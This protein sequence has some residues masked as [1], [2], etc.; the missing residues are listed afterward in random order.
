MRQFCDTLDHKVLSHR[1]DTGSVNSYALNQ[2]V[3]N[4]TGVT[5]MAMRDG[6][7]VGFAEYRDSPQKNSPLRTCQVALL[8]HQDHHKQG[9]G[10]TL[11]NEVMRIAKENGFQ[12]IEW[13][14]LLRNKAMIEMIKKMDLSL[15]RCPDDSG[16]LMAVLAEKPAVPAD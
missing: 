13:A 14:M 11:N 8:V 15:Q 5:L 6:K 3:N 2:I 1:F 16:Y 4:R 9:I 7:L 12:R 10:T